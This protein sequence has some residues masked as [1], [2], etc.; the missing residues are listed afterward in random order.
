MDA[1]DAH[2]AAELQQIRTTILGGKI[3]GLISSKSPDTGDGFGFQ[4]RR[5]DGRRFAEWVDCDPEGNGPGHLN[6]EP[7]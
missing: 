4:V 1:I 3:T 2:A 6:I 7:E 5:P